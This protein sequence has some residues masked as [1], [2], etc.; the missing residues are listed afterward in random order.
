MRI[1]TPSCTAYHWGSLIAFYIR[2]QLFFRR[3]LNKTKCQC[4]SLT[5]QTFLSPAIKFSPA[6]ALHVYFSKAIHA[7]DIQG[8]FSG[9]TSAADPQRHVA[10]KR[11]VGPMR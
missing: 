3:L 10:D 1:G 11:P 6:C 5:E 7:K 4:L 2:H 8:L 9:T